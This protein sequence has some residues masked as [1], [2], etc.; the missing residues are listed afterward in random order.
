M[1]IKIIL[2]ESK[3][4][5]EAE[6]QTVDSPTVRLRQDVQNKIENLSYIINLL[7]K[8]F[9]AT[10]DLRIVFFLQFLN[11]RTEPLT[12]KDI[13]NGQQKIDSLVAKFYQ[14]LLNGDFNIVTE[15]YIKN[16]EGLLRNGKFYMD[17]SMVLNLEDYMKSPVTG[18]V[19]LR[20]GDNEKDPTNVGAEAYETSRYKGSSASSR[21]SSDI[22]IVELNNSLG[23]H[24]INF[25]N[26][27]VSITDTYD[28]EDAL[29]RLEDAKIGSHGMYGLPQGE[30]GMNHFFAGV[31]ELLKRH[32]LESDTI[33]ML[34]ALLS[35][36][37]KDPGLLFYNMMFQ[38]ITVVHAGGYKGF[39][40][41]L[42]FPVIVDAA[43]VQYNIKRLKQEL[44]NKTEKQ[45]REEYDKEQQKNDLVAQQ[46][47]EE[48]SPIRQTA[49]VPTRCSSQNQCSYMGAQC[50]NLAQDRLVSA[51]KVFE[52]KI[53]IDGE[54]KV[55]SL[56]GG[57]ATTTVLGAFY[58][59]NLMKYEQVRD[60]LRFAPTLCLPLEIVEQLNQRA[61]NY[62]HVYLGSPSGNEFIK[63]IFYYYKRAY[64]NLNSFKYLF[65][66]NKK[67]RRG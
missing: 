29:K 49:Y 11:R 65:S 9:K 51:E 39:N 27:V 37:V 42:Q 10:N 34:K 38:L 53:K 63:T 7:N 31:K 64:G 25:K 48:F 17:Q 26:N 67:S 41:Q 56:F 1:G 20:Q 62:D 50:Y 61:A 21:V 46:R 47:R 24:I 40:V 36:N 18:W 19:G 30:Y 32:T 55:Y 5:R 13:P 28:F 35:G 23:R 2:K 58:F 43:R 33:P 66:E 6:S 4:L 14:P 54:E 60:A 44:A 45:G 16:L 57:G 3:L 15:R 8:Q 22:P 59:L 52:N 12:L